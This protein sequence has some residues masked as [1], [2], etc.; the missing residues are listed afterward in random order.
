MIDIA[1]RHICKIAKARQYLYEEL[2]FKLLEFKG[3]KLAAGLDS[4]LFT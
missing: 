2:G 4:Q 1:Q 3:E